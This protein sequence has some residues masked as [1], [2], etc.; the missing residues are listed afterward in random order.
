MPAAR[1]PSSRSGTGFR[2]WPRGPLV[3]VRR[4]VN[5]TGVSGHA[6]DRHYVDQ[7]ALWAGGRTLEWSF[8]RK[9][10]EVS[11]ADTL[12]LVPATDG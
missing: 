5:L 8:A 9:R 3:N 12:T 1:T 7:T 11:A 10:I 2:S 6:F 4:W